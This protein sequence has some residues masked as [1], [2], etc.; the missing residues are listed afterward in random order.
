MRNQNKLI[1]FLVRRTHSLKSAFLNSLI[2]FSKISEK[3]HNALQ[4]INLKL[5]KYMKKIFLS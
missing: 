2:K 4:K 5:L 3:P 1:R